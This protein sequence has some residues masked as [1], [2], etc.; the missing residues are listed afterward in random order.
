MKKKSKNAKRLRGQI[1]KAIA[2]SGL[3]ML[4]FVGI[5]VQSFGQSIYLEVVN[6][7]IGA[8]N[9]VVELTK[10]QRDKTGKET[11]IVIPGVEFHLY[12]VSDD[13]DKPDT[14]IG[15]RFF[16]NENGM[17]SVEGLNRGDYYFVEIDPTDGYSFDTDSNGE[18]IDTYPFKI[19]RKHSTVR[20]DVYN[21]CQFESLTI[22]KVV[23]N[24]D[25]SPLAKWQRA[26]GFKFK[27]TFSDDGS[28]LY[29]IDG[30]PL[31]T[32]SSGASITLK[33]GQSAIF[34]DIPVGV[35]YTVQET[36][37]LDH[38][39]VSQSHQGN[40]GHQPA[41]ADFINT[42]SP[43]YGSL[44]VTNE[45]TGAE[46]NPELAES[47]FLFELLFE[48]SDLLPE[49]VTVDGLPPQLTEDQRG[50]WFELKHGEQA[51]IEGLPVGLGYVVRQVGLADE[52]GD[53]L[54]VAD[55]GARA[56]AG[57]VEVAG[58]RSLLINLA[59]Y[60]VN[61]NSYVGQVVEGQTLLPFVNSWPDQALD[62]GSLEVSK[63]VVV[64]G[65]PG[66]S[67]ENQDLPSFGFLLVFN[68][69]P[70]DPVEIIIDGDTYELSEESNELSFTLKD[71][72]SILIEDLP[73]GVTFVVQESATVGYE[74][75]I[76]STEGR[77]IAGQ[78]T[79]VEFQNHRVFIHE[80]SLTTLVV[81]N[82]VTGAL[83][84]EARDF[85]FQ[86]VLIVEGR[87]PVHFT[88]K[89]DQS[90]T[91]ED[92]PAGA[93]YSI[94]ESDVY[95]DGFSLVD[96]QNGTGTL[97][98]ADNDAVF[99][100][101]FYR[102]PTVEI[103]GEKTWDL[104][105]FDVRLPESIT[106]RLMNGDDVVDSIKVRPDSDGRWLYS[107]TAYMF[108]DQGNE[109]DY[110]IDELDIL[111]FAK[112]VDGYNVTN[113]AVGPQMINIVG[114]KTWELSGYRVQ[115]PEHI[116]IQLIADDRILETVEVR[117]DA[118]GIWSYSFVVPE[119]DEL[120]NLIEYRVDEVDVP[121]FTKLLRGQNITNVYQVSG[122]G[123]NYV[124]PTADNGIYGF[125]YALNLLVSGL[126]CIL[127]WFWYWRKP[128][129]ARS[130]VAGEG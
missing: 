35:Q 107:F 17:I 80:V 52:S 83:S 81:T 38:T 65:E 44:V 58:I 40:I 49:G 29:Q 84:D 23:K 12:M 56:G 103:Q 60:L 86:F 85:D 105:G 63:V 121:H 31:R 104:Q 34:M 6:R 8:P 71:G 109:I 79:K 3:V 27:V 19:V 110:S 90:I 108:D 99:T 42:Y 127:T 116:L 87:D 118:N 45:V 112:Q 129:G 101:E 5:V 72:E 122:P 64:V 130:A 92:L 125:L 43:R 59:D 119:F 106:I 39:L 111:G 115:L 9:A 68:N 30:G 95:P 73:D 123:G 113:T 66:S 22:N 50:F 114:Y 53:V 76:L 2:L 14:R 36:D 126:I 33:S 7:F 70:E 26:L 11:E 20:V 74:A 57:A 15:G 78:T 51:L 128:K 10:Y 24:S 16:T 93:F 37:L 25:N 48:N 21:W 89:A 94:L 55:D 13:V 88:L 4:L 100:N 97:L 61:P 69:L 18:V 124:P 32:L 1:A 77:I 120:G 98:S 75:A 41:V 54:D 96:V 82:I 62:V 47:V 67:D 28:Y 91:F 102:L 46:Q 117:P